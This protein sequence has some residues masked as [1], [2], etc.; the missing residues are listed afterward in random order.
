VDKLPL[1]LQVAALV[2]YILGWRKRE[3]LDLERRQLDLS[4][5]TLRLDPGATKNREGRV[6]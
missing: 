6:A 2:G 1:E 3:V 5:G 4:T